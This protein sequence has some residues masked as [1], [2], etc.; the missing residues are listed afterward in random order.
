MKLNILHLF[1]NKPFNISLFSPFF[2]WKNYYWTKRRDSAFIQS[3]HE[4]CNRFSQITY[5]LLTFQR[6]M[7]WYVICYEYYWN[8]RR[9]NPAT[10]VLK[11]KWSPSP[12]QWLQKHVI[13]RRFPIRFLSTNRNKKSCS[14]L[15]VTE[16]S[17]LDASHPSHNPLPPWYI[18][19]LVSI[20]QAA[21]LRDCA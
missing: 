3:C 2:R 10:Y 5:S 14:S 7:Y 9:T 12:T 18:L 15:V 13:S 11:V 16:R 21:E 17:S 4:G 20:V 6:I 8:T 19:N 1:E